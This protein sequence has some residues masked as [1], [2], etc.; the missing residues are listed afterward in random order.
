MSKKKGNN[1]N[2]TSN[3]IE[4]GLYILYRK[5]EQAG[6]VKEYMIRFVRHVEVIRRSNSKAELVPINRC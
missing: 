4:Q 5:T 6:S 3:P 1:V 2:K